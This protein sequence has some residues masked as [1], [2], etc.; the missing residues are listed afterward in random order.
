MKYILV[1][2][3]VRLILITIFLKYFCRDI[4]LTETLNVSRNSVVTKQIGFMS[5][6]CGY[7]D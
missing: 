7:V 4:L 1:I 6:V 5:V 3:I 2:I